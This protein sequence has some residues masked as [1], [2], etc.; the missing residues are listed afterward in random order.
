[1]L[2]TKIQLAAMERVRI[3]EKDRVDFYLY[4][5]EFQNFAT[6]SF[7]GILS[8]ARK[9]RLNLTIAHQYIGQLVTDVSTKVRDAIFG[10]VGTMILFRIGGTDAEFLEKEF[11]PEFMLQDLVNLPNH[12]IYLKLMV[13]GVTC[14]PF[15]ASTLPPFQVKT[16]KEVVQMIID[17]S[18]KLYARPRRYVE[19]EINR[20]SGVMGE[21]DVDQVERE[22][23]K[24]SSG[25]R[26]DAVCDSCGTQFAVPFVP[27]PTRAVYC[28]SC[29]EK[30]KS[31]ELAPVRKISANVREKQRYAEELA[32]LG[33]EFERKDEPARPRRKQTQLPRNF[34]RRNA[35]EIAPKTSNPVSLATLTPQTEKKEKKKHKREDIDINELRSAISESLQD[36]IDKNEKA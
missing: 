3:S 22:T 32:E 6:D 36:V 20:W 2:I 8:E 15:S 7:S 10:N 26:H 34:S 27:D 23:R 4:V 18:R 17:R 30:V 19:S 14:R 1:M 5:D 13:D 21:G 31:G 24:T 25:E 16:S 29:L 33:I 35:Q 28:K 12:C 11:S 9:Y